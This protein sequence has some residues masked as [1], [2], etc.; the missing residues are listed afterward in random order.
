M[1]AVL[2]ARLR[3]EHEQN[4][5]EA[6]EADRGCGLGDFIKNWLFDDNFDSGADD[7]QP[8]ASHDRVELDCI[9]LA[10]IDINDE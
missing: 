5:N 10:C 1:L 7:E 2:P 3:A 9:E 8:S 4:E 6:D